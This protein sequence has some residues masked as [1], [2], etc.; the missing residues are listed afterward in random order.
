MYYKIVT[1]IIKI[2][3]RFISFFILIFRWIAFSLGIIKFNDKGLNFT[4]SFWL[5]GIAK[6]LKFY[7]VHRTKRALMLNR[8]I[9]QFFKS[10]EEGIF[11][12]GQI[13]V[14]LPDVK[15]AE[16]VIVNDLRE[17]L[18]EKVYQHK[19]VFLRE[20]DVVFDCGAN[21]GIF[22]IM[23]SRIIKE[24]GRII[25]IEPEPLI[26]ETLHKNL[27]M[28]SLTGKTYVVRSLLSE[29]CGAGRIALDTE[30]F[31]MSRSVEL[32][33]FKNKRFKYSEVTCTTID[34]IVE[35]I[36]LEK[37]DFIK[38]DIE[39]FEVYALLGAQKTIMRFKPRLAISTYH[40]FDD[41]YKIPLLIK[42]LHPGYKIFMTLDV[43][44]AI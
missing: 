5:T 29:T 36:P 28:N 30:R 41:F 27:A 2:I 39:G 37:V 25:C 3:Q 21:I 31:T 20:G 16:K 18:Y 10:S 38:M 6:Q 17:I 22:T 34:H 44:F 9:S 1:I 35:E 8:E 11:W 14:L 12:D 24:Q 4:S 32:I 43:C 7:P 13:R 15:N 33:P 26:A 42:S 23:A 40:K 19:E